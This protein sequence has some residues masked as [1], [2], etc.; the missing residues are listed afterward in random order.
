VTG[1]ANIPACG[2][3]DAT[4]SGAATASLGR[5]APA[6]GLAAASTAV[7]AVNE[8]DV[9]IVTTG[10]SLLAAALVDFPAIL[11][12]AEAP[13]VLLFTLEIVVL[14]ARGVAIWA[15]GGVAFN[16]A[17]GRVT[18]R[19]PGTVVSLFAGNE[20]TWGAESP[21]VAVCVL[22]LVTFFCGASTAAGFIASGAC[23]RGAAITGRT[24]GFNADPSASMGGVATASSWFGNEGAGVSTFFAVTLLCAG[25]A[26]LVSA[27]AA[28]TSFESA[29]GACVSSCRG[30]ASTCAL[31]TMA[32][33]SADERNI[34]VDIELACD[35]E[36]T[37]GAVHLAL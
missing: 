27:E 7:D 17:T 32:A 9:C 20:M 3:G 31:V 33:G 13:A 4:T 21:S 22:L 12:V 28:A 11:F 25:R 34:A 37:L 24:I 2:C 29:A 35:D 18:E 10:V 15:S 26:T 16:D 19:T 30:G 5:E 14:K 1:I 8:P 23:V 6:S 36:E